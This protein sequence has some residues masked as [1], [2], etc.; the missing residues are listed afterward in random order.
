MQNFKP[1]NRRHDKNSHPPIIHGTSTPRPKQISQLL[2]G[3][4]HFILCWLVIP[5]ATLSLQNWPCADS[6][7]NLWLWINRSETL[8]PLNR[9][10]H[11]GQWAFRAVW[12]D[13]IPGLGSTKEDQKRHSRLGWSKVPDPPPPT[14]NQLRT[15]EHICQFANPCKSILVGCWPPDIKFKIEEVHMTPN[16]IRELYLNVV[17]IATKGEGRMWHSLGG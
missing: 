4:T 14:A 3:Q 10:R 6:Y 17:I 1:T 16:K 9:H 5:G 2:I 11:G 7:L 15:K 12:R 13:C 8:C